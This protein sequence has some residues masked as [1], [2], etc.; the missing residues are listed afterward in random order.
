[1]LISNIK[2]TIEQTKIKK[3]IKILDPSKIGQYNLNNKVINLININYNQKKPFK[4][5]PLNQINI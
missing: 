2:K 1:M 4:K 3:N 5:F